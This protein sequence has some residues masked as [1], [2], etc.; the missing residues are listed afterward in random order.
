MV[1]LRR[2]IDRF[3]DS[4]LGPGA[5]RQLRAHLR[6]CAPCRAYYDRQ[7][8]LL[9]A[10]AG[11]P[12]RP[13]PAEHTRA[14]ARARQVPATALPIRPDGRAQAGWCA[15]PVG[16][17]AVTWYRLLLVVPRWSWA[18][19]G[20]LLALSFILALRSSSQPERVSGSLQQPA[21]PVVVARLSK[22]RAVSAAGH[23]VRLGASIMS[24]T[25]LAT[26]SHGLAELEL[27]GG[28][29]VRI[30]PGSR[31]TFV[32]SPEQL[33]L[34]QGTIWCLVTGRPGFL[35]RTAEAEAVV[36]GTS[37]LVEA[38]GGATEVRVVS[39]T[40]RVRDRAGSGQIEVSANHR[41]RVVEGQAPGPL[42]PY[43]AEDDLDR[44]A[45]FFGEL[46]RALGEGLEKTGRELKRLL[47]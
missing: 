29:Q 5:E 22:G 44:W 41:T 24:D 42:R 30:F 39:G 47:R 1:H 4:G 10:L 14:V 20:L 19:V 21:T 38:R 45:R 37:F 26:G 15:R 3:M 28:G 34:E 43:R 6:A 27:A 18:A 25:L 17:I 8:V 13:T 23:P 33:N 31:L 40:V 46:L 16:L 2:A 35:V 32:G 12:S 11:D 9:R 7:Q 36:A